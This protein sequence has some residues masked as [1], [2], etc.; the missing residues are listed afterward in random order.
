LDPRLLLLEAALQA[1]L[2]R[3]MLLHKS[4]YLG[5]LPAKLFHQKGLGGV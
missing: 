2:N 3:D 5:L 1:F 4:V